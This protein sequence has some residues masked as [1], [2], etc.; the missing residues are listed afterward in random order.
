M[1]YLTLFTTPKP[2][3]DPH[4]ARIQ[5]NA[6]RSWM[7]LGDEVDVILVGDE[8]GVAEVARELGVRHV[9]EVARNS[10]GTPLIP[11]IF[12]QARLHSH[13][14]VLAYVNADILLTPSF[15]QGARVVHNVMPRFLIVG[16]RWDLEVQDDLVIEAGWEEALRQQV[17]MHGRRHPPG[18]SDYFI[19]P[20][21]CFQN[22]PPMAVGRAG[23][24]NWMIYFARQ[25]GWP[26]VDASRS[27]FIVHQNHD[28]RHL[29]GGQPH[30]R[31][32]ETEENV[33]L[34][35]G[36]RTIFTLLDATHVLCE[37]GLRRAPLTWKKFWREVEI[38]PLISLHSRVLGWL[39]FALFHP[40]K[41]YYETYAWLAAVTR[42]WRRR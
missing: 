25:Q 6:I 16:Q 14:P 3:T 41:A 32:P 13:S 11:A 7:A 24:D 27:I 38:F 9:P 29:P 39:T 28:Y 21:E 22:L 36:R 34:G 40:R 33:R 10:Y 26:V 12:E 17:Q 18:G 8:V 5:R 4:I 23:W 19:F 15:L 20:R 42:P 1:T 35:G 37:E 2:F 30:Y 31:L